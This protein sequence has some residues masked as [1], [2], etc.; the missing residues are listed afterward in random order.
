M[1]P[2]ERKILQ[3]RDALN[4][5]EQPEVEAIW[6]GVR[7]GLEEPRKLRARR[8]WMVAAAAILLLLSMNVF[9][10]WEKGGESEPALSLADVSPELAVKERE[11]QRLISEKESAISKEE[12]PK[13]EF[14]ALFHELEILE[15]LNAEYRKEL[16]VYGNNE[17]L[18][19]TLIRYYELKILILEQ[20]ENEIIK[21][22]YNESPGPIY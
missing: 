12:L 2:L 18:I 7:Q 15:D 20:I 1:D 13:A 6:E 8:W 9:L 10:L 22:K 17:R 4:R 21:K 5:V 11:F 19:N 3:D 14:A 16:P